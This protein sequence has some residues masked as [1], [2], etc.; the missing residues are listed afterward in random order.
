MNALRVL[1]AACCGV[2]L[3]ASVGCVMPDHLS[4]VQKDVADVQ[5]QLQRIEQ[6]QSDIETLLA[7]RPAEVRVDPL[8]TVAPADLAELRLEIEQF[9]RQMSISDQRMRELDQRLDGYS[10]DLQLARSGA[11]TSTD[12]T[13][14]GTDPMGTDLQDPSINR[15]PPSAAIPDPEALYNTAYADFSNGNYEQANSGIRE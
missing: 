13:P 5:Q 14:A 15:P 9:S 6:T 7:E 3:A 4:Q 2:G 12:L 11:L 8:D 10:Q 1:S